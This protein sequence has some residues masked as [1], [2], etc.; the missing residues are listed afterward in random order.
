MS[1]TRFHTLV[2]AR[3]LKAIEE[4]ATDLSMGVPLSQYE[5]EVGYCSG[6]RAA[7]KLC[8]EVEREFD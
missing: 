2:K 6:L 8:E 4:R 3:I 5:R 7:L 1:E